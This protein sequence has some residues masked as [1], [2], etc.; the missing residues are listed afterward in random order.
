MTKLLFRTLPDQ[1]PAGS[2]LA[3]FP[4]NIPTKMHDVLAAR[5]DGSLQRYRWPTELDRTN[6]LPPLKDDY[7]RKVVNDLAAVKQALIV[8]AAKFVSNVTER[9]KKVVG[10]TEVRLYVDGEELKLKKSIS[11]PAYY[12]C[13]RSHLEWE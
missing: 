2:V 8:D 6:P 12:S 11:G 10:S 13:Q 1:Y 3:H 9:K 5:N 7:E 4:F